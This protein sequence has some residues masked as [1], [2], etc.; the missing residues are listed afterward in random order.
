MLHVF[1]AFTVKCVFEV[2]LYT[3][4][5]NSVFE[6]GHVCLKLSYTRVWRVFKIEYM[7]LK[8]SY[9]CLYVFE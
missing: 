4:L 2:K 3:F 6:V 1:E 5:K 9:M 8:L 7:F